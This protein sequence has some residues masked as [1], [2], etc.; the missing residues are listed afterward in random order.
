[1]DDREAW[2][3]AYFG[4][5]NL[6]LHSHKTNAFHLTSSWHSANK[7]EPLSQLY[8]SLNLLC[9]CN[10]GYV[11]NI[12]G[13]R[14]L[15][16]KARSWT[17]VGMDTF[18]CGAVTGLTVWGCICLYMPGLRSDLNWACVTVRRE[19]LSSS[20]AGRRGR[21]VLNPMLWAIQCCLSS[22]MAST[23]ASHSTILNLSA[24]A[25]SDPITSSSQGWAGTNTNVPWLVQ[26]FSLLCSIFTSRKN[27]CI[28]YPLRNSF[29]N[30]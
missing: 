14:K 20:A 6:F 15:W 3:M 28:F 2:P 23:Y 17:S 27:L 30:L 18:S 12:E 8:I 19:K 11:G 26:G 10:T 5:L 1:M 25:A 9:G 16:D 22:G 21:F 13:R 24:R 29:C 4:M 7:C